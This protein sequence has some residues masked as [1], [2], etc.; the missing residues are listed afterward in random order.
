MHQ[1]STHTKRERQAE[2]IRHT[3][4]RR[5]SKTR[6]TVIVRSDELSLA[7]QR[8]THTQG[9]T[10]GEHVVLAD[11]RLVLHTKVELIAVDRGAVRLGQRV[12]IRVAVG[13]G[14]RLVVL[15]PE[16]REVS[17]KREALEQ[18]PTEAHES[19][20]ETTAT[21]ENIVVIAGASARSTEI[22]VVVG[23]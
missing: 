17:T 11:G 4:T 14:D 23:C 6:H 20:A 1:R 12:D 15:A 16:I 7:I 19:L 3:I 5:R 10:Y 2:G 21:L 18:L 9:S 13:N 8:V 22:Q